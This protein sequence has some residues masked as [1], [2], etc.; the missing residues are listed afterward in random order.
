MTSRLLLE[1]DGSGFAGW[2]RQPGAR[3]VQSEVERAL[4]VILRADVSL[5]VFPGTDHA[6]TDAMRQAGCA[7][8]ASADHG[9]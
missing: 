3:T 4:G 1:Y 2:A 8:L 5:T 7:E 9:D 6:L